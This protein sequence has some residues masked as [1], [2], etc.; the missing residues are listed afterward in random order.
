M[1]FDPALS[2]TKDWVRLLIGDDDPANEA[3]A[4]ATIEAI[5]T[6]VTNLGATGEGIKYCAAAQAGELL[7]ASW[8]ANSAGKV[9]KAVSKLRIQYGGGG[10]GSA[11]ETYNTYLAGLKE[12]C[13]R[14]SL[15]GAPSA[16][17]AL[18][19]AW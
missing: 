17:P 16:R 14:L 13:T 11:I 9:E 7:A 2:T 3:L 1:S 19:K 5:I 8:T 4:D 15:S 6:E 12:K 10:A 18:L